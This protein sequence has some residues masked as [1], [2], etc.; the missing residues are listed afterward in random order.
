MATLT[1]AQLRDHYQDEADS[2]VLYERLGPML[3]DPEQRRVLEGL[4]LEERRHLEHFARLLGQA[5][6]P[7]PSARAAFMLVLARLVGPTRVLGLLWLS[8]GREVRRFLREAGAGLDDPALAGMARESAAHAEALGRLISRSD[9]PWHRLETG[10]VIRNV[11]YGFNDGLT[12]NFGL[13]AGVVG[14]SVP[15][16]VVVL[17]GLSG[18]VASASSMAA[19]G[20]LAAQSQLEVQQNE[21]NTQRAELA[22]WPERERTYLSQL[23]R[24]RGLLP[25]EADAAAVRVVEDPVLALREL[26]REKLG[27]AEG[28]DSPLHEGFTTGFAT[29][30]GAL[31]PI[32][33]FLFGGG[34]VAVGI[35]FA[36]SMLAHFLVG[37]AR[38]SFTGRPWFRSGFDMFAVG[39]GVAAA[40]YLVGFL[41]TGVLAAG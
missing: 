39:L 9:D 13:I 11:V 35:S 2:A 17:T 14:A 21:V 40:G 5:T 30:F 1:R 19:S 41:L 32:L 26:A 20:Y 22:L 6:Q 37:A 18:L 12:A 38:S 24:K 27:V 31:V 3:P 28:G 7:R 16:D 4:A 36:L 15:R 25:A 8:E 10:G 29:V 34:P 33:P 23:Y